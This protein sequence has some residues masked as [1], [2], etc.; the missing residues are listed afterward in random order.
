MR[1][2]QIVSSLLTLLLVVLGIP[3]F[4]KGQQGSGSSKP[5]TEGQIT[6]TQSGGSTVAVVSG[7]AA[8]PVFFGDGGTASYVYSFGMNGATVKSQPFSAQ[9]INESIQI[10]SDGNRIIRKSTTMIYRD[11]EGRSR[12]EQTISSVGPFAVAGDP[13]VTIYINDPVAGVSYTLNSRTKTGTRYT[14]PKGEQGK[15]TYSTGQ[16][17]TIARTDAV[18][19]AELEAR[20]KAE[21]EAKMRAENKEQ[22]RVS[23]NSVVVTEGVA[24]TST[25]SGTMPKKEMKE[26]SL[27]TQTMEGV[28]VEGTRY[29]SIIPA[30][31]IGNELP[32]NVV[33]E[34]WYSQ[35]LRQIIYSKTTDPRYGETIYRL[36]NITRTD[37]DRSL[38]ELPA[39]YTVSDVKSRVTTTVSDKMKEEQRMKEEQKMKERKPQ[40]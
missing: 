24:T 17:V 35:E 16:N 40:Q 9:A 2:R 18:Q 12:R 22:M 38:F 31:Q 21:L 32:I 30:G 7:Q 15:L 20:Q 6:T 8:S 37:P 27:G 11:S 39:D 36:T 19:K 33:I 34:K 25:Y 10:L 1:K 13:P 14:M 3:V 29:T 5:K 4:T 23:G 28:R 26:E